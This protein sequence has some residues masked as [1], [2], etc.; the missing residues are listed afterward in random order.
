[1]G[2]VRDDGDGDEDRDGGKVG[3][4][5]RDGGRMLRHGRRA[6]TEINTGVANK[7]EDG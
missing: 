7:K 6:V 1:V 3:P 2:D 5:V 4:G